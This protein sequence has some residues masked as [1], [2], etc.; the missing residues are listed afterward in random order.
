MKTVTEICHVR[1]LLE[2][3]RRAG[4]TIGLVPTMG[5]LHD[6]HVALIREARKQC[7]TVVVSVFVN[8]KQFGPGEDFLDYPRDLPADSGVCQREAVDYLFVPAEDEMYSEEFLTFVEVEGLT[9]GLCGQARPGHFKGV[10]TVVTKLF[11]IVRPH[12]AFFGEKDAQQ[13][14]V[15]KRMVRDLDFGVEIVGVT[16]VREK[17]GLA[18]SSRNRYLDPEERKA[19]PILYR[20]LSK[21]REMIVEGERVAAKIKKAMNDVLEQEP[22]V[23]PEYLAICQTEDLDEIEELH[24]DVIIALA[25]RIGKARLID[26]LFVSLGD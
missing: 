19:A 22:R 7:D 15:V 20:S 25:S 12:R 26:S 10:A 13:L 11:N 24:G 23:F 14:L 8:R 1:E 17:D 6:G 5:C 18:M 2:I 3:E 9:E 4:K 21:A 16:T